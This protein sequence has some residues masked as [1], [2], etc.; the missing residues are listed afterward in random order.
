MEAD[1]YP[2]NK[3]EN[4]L[5][6]HSAFLGV[7]NAAH[8]ILRAEYPRRPAC[9]SH[10]VLSELDFLSI[11]LL[12]AE[13]LLCFGK[14]RHQVSDYNFFKKCVLEFPLWRHGIGSI[15]GA[16][17]HRFHPRPSAVLFLQ[18]RCRSQLQVTI[19]PWL[20]DS[21]RGGAAKK[22]KRNVG[23]SPNLGLDRV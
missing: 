6:T 1:V 17:G 3:E 14:S 10:S 21:I 15:L 13:C 16:P 19:D 18:L 20:G 5:F 12:L 7:Q 9:I 23:L 11:T 4:G 2:K 8:L 22:E